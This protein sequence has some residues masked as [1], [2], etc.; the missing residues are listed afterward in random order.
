M[1]F[2]A[3]SKYFNKKALATVATCVVLAA[4]CTD[5]MIRYDNGD[6]RLRFDISLDSSWTKG[7]V[8]TRGASTDICIEEIDATEDGRQLYLISESEDL[9]TYPAA[10]PCTRGT[11]TTEAT[12]PTTFGLSAICYNSSEPASD[13]SSFTANF[14]C[15]M[16]VKKSDGVFPGLDWPG[17]GRIRFLGYAPYAS[18]ANGIT[19][20]AAG[21]HPQ[22]DFTV[23]TDV[24]NQVDLLRASADTDGRGGS[25]VKMEFRHALSAITVRTGDAML[26]S[27]ITNVTISGVKGKGTLVLSS[28]NWITKGENQT[29][30]V[31]TKTTVSGT[32]DNNPYAS[33]SL[34]IAG[35]NDGLTF[36]LIPQEL[37]TEARLSI[38]FTDKLTK[39]KRTL[40][41]SIGGSGKKW[42]SGK[43]YS[44][45]VSSTGVIIT[46]IVEMTDTKGN[47][48]PDSV[49]YTGML[50]DVRLKTFVRVT[51]SGVETKN[52][53]V[54]VKIMAK[55]DNSTDW[56]EVT[57]LPDDE[58]S[59][60][61]PSLSSRDGSLILPPQPVFKNTLHK[62]FEGKEELAD[63]RDLSSAESANCYMI[64]NPGTYRFR[65]VYGNAL[66]N[67]APNTSAYTINRTGPDP[68]PGMKWFVDHSDKKIETPYIKEQI[69]QNGETLKDAF[70]LWADSPE[71]IDNVTLED[72]GDYINFHVGRHTIAQGNA[73]IALRSDKNNIV[74]S[75]H[76][77]VTEKDWSEKRITTTDALGN[78]YVLPQTTL[79]YCNARGKSPKRSI[80]VKFVFDL[81]NSGGK[82]LEVT[83]LNGKDIEFGQR[84]ILASDAGDNPYYQWGRKDAM[85][86][87]IYDKNDHPTESPYYFNN[88]NNALGELSMVNKPVYDYDPEYRFTRSVTRSGASLGQSISFPHHFIMGDV[89]GDDMTYRQHW[90]NDSKVSEKYL[91]SGK[92]MYNAWNS[93]AS[94]SGVGQPVNSSLDPKNC[95]PITK[96]IYDPSPAGYHIPS[97]GAYSNIIKWGGEYGK[98]EIYPSNIPQWD[99]ARRCWTM[100][101]NSD[102]SGDI[103]TLY[104][105]GIRDMSLKGAIGAGDYNT[106]YTN[107]WLKTNTWP[108]FRTTTFIASATLTGTQVMILYCDTRNFKVT[109][110]TLT[111]GQSFGTMAQS[112]NSYGFTVWPVAE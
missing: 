42:E 57:W 34:N 8:T 33:S 65:T 52:L 10:T 24:K 68:E 31:A 45:S 84:E 63:T 51:Q 6:G 41:A 25:A 36:F 85:V 38:T 82:N 73:V 23:S 49:P 44:Y 95:I 56:E 102:G 108:A 29:Y 83:S 105:T 88:G 55:P 110:N 19:H 61:K 60:T 101:S 92:K 11:S 58:T 77:W 40:S 76:I 47:S 75:W 43:L 59:G 35:S 9:D 103:V 87:G 2:N 30:S 70:I 39:T 17:S 74:W 99:E 79:G 21:E 111:G 67:G 32:A 62:Y 93:T 28:G 80:K 37:T 100:H 46:P 107:E 26:S 27:E 15:N 97:A 96:T 86:P 72:N 91:E 112:N 3:S 90:H 106:Y 1:I 109:P 81:T 16:E 66:K 50:H 4:G 89:V 69:Y 18:T 14:A 7:G 78:T 98:I 13:L 5:E 104:A 22:L 53:A 71:L 94:H 20:S 54:P 64:S 12:F 48:L